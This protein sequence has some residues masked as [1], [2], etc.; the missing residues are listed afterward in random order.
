M[1][2]HTRFLRGSRAI[3]KAIGRSERTVRR[4]AKDGRLQAFKAGGETSPLTVDRKALTRLR[5]EED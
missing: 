3:A 5:G 2:D 1:T 4:M